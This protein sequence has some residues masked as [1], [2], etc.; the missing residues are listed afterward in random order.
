MLVFAVEVYDRQ[1]EIINT[2]IKNW[3]Q[4]TAFQLET[5]CISTVTLGKVHLCKVSEVL[6]CHTDNILM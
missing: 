5:K 3:T 6:G 1:G 4:D 2:Q